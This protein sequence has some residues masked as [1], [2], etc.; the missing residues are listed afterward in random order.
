VGK[1]EI[2]RES[3]RGPRTVLVTIKEDLTGT[4]ASGDNTV[5]L[6]DVRIEGDQLSFKVTVKFGDREVPMEF[7]GK[8]EGATLKGQFTSPRGTREATGKKAVTSL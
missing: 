8:L 6:T 7:K 4:Y 2:T 3:S 5:A 1:W